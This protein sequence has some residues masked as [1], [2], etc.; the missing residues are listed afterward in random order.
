MLAQALVKGGATVQGTVVRSAPD[1]DPISKA[2]CT[3]QLAKERARDERVRFVREDLPCFDSV[4]RKYEVCCILW[5]TK[6]S[7][8]R[9]WPARFHD[10]TIV[11]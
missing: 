11:I 6:D 3:V 10:S 5:S 8:T 9:S 1:V 2:A 4:F 7:T